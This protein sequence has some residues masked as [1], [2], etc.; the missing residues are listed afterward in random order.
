MIAALSNGLFQ[1][2]SN[3]YKD[4]IIQENQWLDSMIITN[5]SI[6]MMTN[7]IKH[8]I[9]KEY[10]LSADWDNRWRTGGRLDEVIDEAHLSGEWQIKA[11]KKFVQERQLRLDK[12]QKTIPQQLFDKMEIN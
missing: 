5:T 1:L 6:N 12:I 8:P 3:K 10:S 4:E 2:Q 9:V 7:W 11:I